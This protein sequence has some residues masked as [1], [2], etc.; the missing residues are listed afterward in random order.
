MRKIGSKCEERRT[1]WREK[2]TTRKDGGRGGL[3]EE[4]KGKDENNKERGE[5]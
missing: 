2:E 4:E 5:G 1:G 3:G